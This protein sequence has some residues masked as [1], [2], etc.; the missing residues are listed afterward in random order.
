[1]GHDP[2][3]DITFPFPLIKFSSM[4]LSLG[5]YF[6]ECV[7]EGSSRHKVLLLKH[8]ECP[9]GPIEILSLSPTLLVALQEYCSSYSSVSRRLNHPLEK[10]TV[11]QGKRAHLCSFPQETNFPEKNVQVDFFPSLRRSCCFLGKIW[12]VAV[13]CI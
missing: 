5:C 8:P 10:A 13:M 9:Q 4:S 7:T 11:S 3:K 6:Q 1:M 2:G 12:R